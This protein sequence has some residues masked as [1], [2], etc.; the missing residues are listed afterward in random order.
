[1]CGLG[2]DTFQMPPE[3]GSTV[4][5]SV[6]PT[7]Q[8]LQILKRFQPWDKKDIEDAEILIKVIS[9]NFLLLHKCNE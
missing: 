7:S 4:K 1:M 2:E 3:D 8:R 9:Q 5:V 6:D